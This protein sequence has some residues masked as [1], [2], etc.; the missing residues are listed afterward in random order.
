[1][2][3]YTIC[4]LW[5]VLLPAAHCNHTALSS[6]ALWG[7][8]TVTVAGTL[9]LFSC[10]FP[11]RHR[12]A[13]GRATG[14]VVDS[15]ATQTVCTPVYDG[16]ALA[17]CELQPWALISYICMYILTSLLCHLTINCV[18][19]YHCILVSWANAF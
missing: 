5:S 10:P 8:H 3:V 6:V 1:V 9:P 7:T 14:L 15:G 13:N 17:Q 16:Y 19:E 4:A 12:F 18:E 11:P 2:Y